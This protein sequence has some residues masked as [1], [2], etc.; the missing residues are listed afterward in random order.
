MS[1]HTPELIPEERL[2]KM[3][4]TLKALEHPIR[5]QIVIILMK[6]ERSVGEL[7]K[8]LRI[9]Q[10]LTSQQLSK[11]RFSGVL[12][13]RRDGNVVFYSI[14]NSAVKNIVASII[15]ECIRQ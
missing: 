6:G 3:V 12:K 4:E 9:A 2:E 1:S 7:V 13:P 11:L 5:L 8:K 14:K 10:S 15:K